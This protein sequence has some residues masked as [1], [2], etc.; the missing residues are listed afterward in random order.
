MIAAVLAPP[1]PAPVAAGHGRLAVARHAGGAAAVGCAP[2]N[3][4][5]LIHPRRGAAVWAWLATFGGGLM[6]GDDLDLGVTVGAGARLLLTTQ[7][8]TKVL[9]SADGGVARSRIAAT[10]GAGALLALWGDPLACFADARYRG[11]IAID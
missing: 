3:P 8:A 6:P 7:S 9:T 10:V 1:L 11:R 2:T 5:K 4:P